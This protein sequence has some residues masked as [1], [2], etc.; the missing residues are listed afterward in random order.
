MEA[1]SGASSVLAVVSIAI[2]LAE[3]IHKLVRFCKAVQDAPAGLCDLVADLES[4]SQILLQSPPIDKVAGIEHFTADVLK[5][6]EHTVSKL[7]KKIFQHSVDLQSPNRRR[8]LRGGFKF[9]L[10]EHEIQSLR[11]DIDRAKSNL[12]L[13][14]ANSLL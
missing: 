13:A 9:V 6:C 11:L 10:Q 7:Q 8:K 14:K 4:L 5:S 12:L 2:Q 1:L 3:G